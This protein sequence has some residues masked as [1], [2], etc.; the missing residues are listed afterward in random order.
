MG[1]PELPER[2]PEKPPFGASCNGCGYCCAMAHE[3]IS[4]DIRGPCPA[5]EFADGIFHRGMVRQPSR[6]MHLPNNW[7]DEAIGSLFAQ[8]LGV[9]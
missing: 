1:G 7:A 3:Y 2:G 8:M 9:G 4:R 6:Y 5:L